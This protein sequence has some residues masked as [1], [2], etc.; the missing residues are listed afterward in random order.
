MEPPLQGKELVIVAQRICPNVVLLIRDV[1]HAA[2]IAARDP[3]HHDEAFGQVWQELF[4]KEH[5]VLSDFQNSHK[6]KAGLTAAQHDVARLGNHDN[7]PQLVWLGG[8]LCQGSRG[9]KFLPVLF[10]SLS[11]HSTCSFTVI[12]AMLMLEMVLMKV[13]VLSSA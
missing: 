3:L 6:L 2:R 9:C 7:R 5:S 1:A 10:P 12:I 11:G 13:L 4:E 8:K